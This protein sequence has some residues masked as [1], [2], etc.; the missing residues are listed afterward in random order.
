MVLDQFFNLIKPGFYVLDLGAGSGKQAA[1]LVELGANVLA[2]DRRE[3]PEHNSGIEWVISPIGEWIVHIPESTRF[4]AII[5]RNVIQFFEKG[6]VVK[7]LLPV[8][9]EHLK[10]GGVFAIETFYEG[11]T[12]PFEQSFLSYW[13]KDELKENFPGWEIVVSEMKKEKGHDLTGNTR[14]FSRTGLIV[15]KP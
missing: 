6:F 8:L 13:T 4:D 10:N 7:K 11:P 15:R 3:P 2:V 9:S 14:E 5:A 1:K 12:P